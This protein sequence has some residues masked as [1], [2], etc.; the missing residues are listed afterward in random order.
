M[1]SL[2]TPSMS[3]RPLPPHPMHA[4]L[5]LSEGAMKPRPS[6]CRGTMVK[7]A[8]AATLVG[9]DL[10]RD[11]EEV[12]AHAVQQDAGDEHPHAGSDPAVG[13][14]EVPQ[15]P[16]KHAAEHDRLDPIA[17][18]GERQ[19]QHEENLRHLPQGLQG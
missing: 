8:P 4:M 3:E 5:S 15:R 9:V 14:P 13:K 18:Q 10:A 6:T 12:V 16:R 7:A 2:A 11:E 19:G 17:A 1:F